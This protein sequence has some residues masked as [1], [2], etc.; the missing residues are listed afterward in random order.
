[1]LRGFV[2]VI[3]LITLGP[4]IR[5]GCYVTVRTKKVIEVGNRLKHTFS[6]KDEFFHFFWKYVNFLRAPVW[7]CCYCG[8]VLQFVFD[9]LQHLL[10]S[11]ARGLTY[12]DNVELL[13]PLDE[14]HTNW[15]FYRGNIKQ[16]HHF[17]RVAD[18]IKVMFLFMFLY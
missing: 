13:Y 12:F 3:V 14:F 15:I 11:L 10:I 1:M 18:T 2:Y 5:Y 8:Q 4:K 9:D 6:F 17:Y 7:S 16:K